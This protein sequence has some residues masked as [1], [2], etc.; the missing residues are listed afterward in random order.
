[1]FEPIEKDR[2]HIH[3]LGFRLSYLT[4]AAVVNVL[5]LYFSLFP[6]NMPVG[7]MDFVFGIFMLSLSLVL[8]APVFPYVVWRL[9]KRERPIFWSIAL[10][11]AALP[12]IQVFIL[13][14]FG[15]KTR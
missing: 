10:F 9:V 7:Y 5:F 4:I 3:R 6:R 11:V 13:T 2:S 12:L 14:I 15:I 8:S 1:M